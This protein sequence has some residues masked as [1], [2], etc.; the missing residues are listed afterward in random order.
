MELAS[1]YF[2]KEA[3]FTRLF[4]PFALGIIA[5]EKLH[6]SVIVSVVIIFLSVIGSWSLGS[7]NSFNLY[8]WRQ[9]G[10]VFLIALFFGCGSLQLHFFQRRFGPHN[11][12]DQ[13]RSVCK[14]VLTE[15][16]SEKSNSYKATGRLIEIKRNDSS[17]QTNE[18]ILIYFKKDS[19]CKKLDYGDQII[20]SKSFQPIRNSG[21]PGAFNYQ[22]YCARQGIFQQVFLNSNEFILLHEKNKNTFFQFLI[23]IRREV[24]SIIQQ[25]IPG[26]KEA[27]LA[28]A[29][30]IGYKDDLDKELVSAY[31]GAGVVHIIAISGLHL[32]IIY[33]LLNGVFLLWNKKRK[34]KWAKPIV[35]ISG[36]W[37]FSLIA[38]SS[39]SVLRSALMFTFIVIGDSLSRKVSIYNTLSASAFI[40]LWYNP[41]WLWDVGF[42]LSYCAV[43]SIVIFYKHVY[44]L[45]FFNNKIADAI[46]KLNAI[47]ISAQLL[48][49]PLTIYY[50][51][52]FPNY[53]LLA[54]LVAIPLS[55]IILI[56]EILLCALTIVPVA[57]EWLGWILEKLIFIMNSFIGWIDQLPGSVWNKLQIDLLQSILLFIATTGTCLGILIRNKKSL[58]TGLASLSIFFLIRLLS[59]S[60][61]EQ[62]QKLIVYN[63][64]GHLA[65]DFIQGRNYF[66]QGDSLLKTDGFLKNF[67][68]EPSRTLQ[69]VAETDILPGFIREGNLLQFGSKKILLLDRNFKLPRQEGK[70]NIDL[71]IVSQNPSLKPKEVMKIFNIK[72][73][74]IDNSNNWWRINNWEEEC[75]KAGLDFHRTDTEGA[76]VLNMQ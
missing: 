17:F 46:W 37:L 50:F 65:I 55:S 61:C 6:L 28:E 10:G 39:A 69:R 15:P 73:I 52:Q 71:V 75:R 63:I 57:A 30:L 64:P 35:I 13:T 27:G 72:K 18:R 41:Y 16:L 76:F 19:I 49:L 14:I 67:H 26:D 11:T 56:G 1:S 74:I 2:W 5:Q 8:R 44:S 36:L 12:Q 4:L 25:Y 43:L 29:L 32:G 60:T 42:Q 3:P 22:Q 23:D 20:F 9:L 31:S 24:I 7:F 70:I 66:F 58:F 47:T 54:N 34:S 33:G 40:L 51:H 59:F 38:G 45:L 48:T 68:L 21:N 62:Q 53:F